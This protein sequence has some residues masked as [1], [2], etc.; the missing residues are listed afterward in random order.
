MK[1]QHDHSYGTEFTYQYNGVEGDTLGTFLIAD[2]M[3]HSAAYR[4]ADLTA[5]ELHFIYDYNGPNQRPAHIDDD[6]NFVSLVFVKD[7]VETVFNVDVYHSSLSGGVPSLNAD[8]LVHAMSGL[9][10]ENDPGALRIGF[11]DM[12]YLGDADFDDVVFDI[13]VA[14]KVIEIF[15]DPDNDVLFGGAGDDT[16][17]GGFGNDVLIGGG[18]ADHLY[19]GDGSDI[20]VFDTLDGYADTIHDFQGGAGGDVINLTDVLSGYDSLT[21]AFNDFVMMTQNGADAQIWV[22]S[23]GA[24][25][26]D[27][28]QLATIL[29]GTDGVDLAG[30]LAQGNLVLDQAAVY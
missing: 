24:A 21:D 4:N 26:G 12:N 27:F 5:G 2:G 16:L 13:R 6:G 18:G 28:V 7:G 19:G 17:Y 3:S 1:N 20:F 11:E 25:G 15:G 14:N 30:L 8:G 10:D 22:N 9:A 29:G 23:T